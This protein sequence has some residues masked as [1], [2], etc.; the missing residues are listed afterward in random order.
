M[1][2]MTPIVTPLAASRVWSSGPELSERSSAAAGNGADVRRGR[3]RADRCAKRVIARWCLVRR[4][5][6]RW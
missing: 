3:P 2:G 4:C 1:A 5:R 6:S